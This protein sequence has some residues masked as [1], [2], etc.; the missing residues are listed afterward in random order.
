MGNSTHDPS[1]LRAIKQILL[2]LLSNAIKF[3]PA[4]GEVTTSVSLKNG[5]AVLSVKDT[6]IGIP[7]DQL[8]RL[9]NPFVQL[10]NDAGRTQPGT[11][12]GL[13]LVR[14]LAEMHNGTLK[15]E[16]EEHVGTTVS[17]EIPLRQPEVRAA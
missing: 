4:G 17:V 5:I 8:Y 1:Q 7:A 9:G 14:A 10:R 3:T 12:L 13:A 16:S 11:G 15:I 6:G 2:N